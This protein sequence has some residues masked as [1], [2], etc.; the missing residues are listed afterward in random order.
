MDKVKGD[1]E[2]QKEIIFM[3]RNICDSSLSIDAYLMKVSKYISVCVGVSLE[4]A[5]NL[6]FYIVRS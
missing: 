2:R 6:C 4:A 1:R 5:L 3:L